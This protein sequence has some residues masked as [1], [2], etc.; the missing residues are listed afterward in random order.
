MDDGVR[1]EP[2]ELNVRR[3]G[4]VIGKASVSLLVLT[5]DFC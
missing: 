5:K 4:F 1:D 2:V 3:S